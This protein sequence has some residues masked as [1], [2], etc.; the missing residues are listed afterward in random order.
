MAIDGGVGANTLV[1]KN[2]A[3]VDL[4]NAD[5]TT[6][7]AVNVANF[8][9]VDASA[10]AVGATITGSSAANTI[11]GGAGNDTI[12]GAGGAD[13]INGGGGDDTI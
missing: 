1:L 6:G 12:D 9:N 8:V 11:T 5:Q 13:V 10:L 7:D 2:A 3:T 4:G